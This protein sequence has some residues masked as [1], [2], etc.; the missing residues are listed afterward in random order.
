MSWFF[1]PLL[2]NGRDASDYV[3]L[4]HTINNCIVSVATTLIYAYLCI[5][6]FAKS[7]NIKSESMSETQKQVFFQS[8]LICLFNAIAAY[9]YV[10]MQFFGAPPF[11]ILIGQVAW[12]WSHGSVCLIYITMNRTVRRGVIDLFI[13][14]SIRNKH[15]IGTYRKEIHRLS[16]ATNPTSQGT[17]DVF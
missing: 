9:I 10:Y 14:V 7:K 3:N 13:P 5:I 4:E 8:V 1:N 2:P 15:K 16:I 12:Q 11:V 17:S 6:L